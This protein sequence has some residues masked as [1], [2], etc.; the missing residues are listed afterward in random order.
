MALDFIK[1]IKGLVIRE[2]SDMTKQLQVQVSASATTGTKTTVEAAQTANRTLTLPNATDTLVGKATSDTLTNK[3][4][5]ADGAGNSITN[6]E[7]ADIKAAAAI[8][9]TKL[10]A[11]TVS[12]ALQSDGSGVISASSVT[13]AELGYVSG[14]TSA[15]QTQINGKI[16]LADSVTLTNKTIDGDDNTIQDLPITALKTNLTDASKF[17]VRD[18]S[19]V[20]TSATKDVPA[21]VV[22]GTTDTQTLTN[23]SLSDSTTFFIDETNPTSKMQFQLSGIT[24]GNTRSIA[25]PDADTTLVGTDVSQALSNKTLTSPGIDIAVLDGQASTPSNPS[26]GFYKLY[27]KDSTSKLTVLNSGGTETSVG[28]FS[29]STVGA[30]PNADGATFNTGTGAFNLELADATHPGIVS[31]ASQTMAGLKTFSSG[32]S[33]QTLFALS[34]VSDAATTGADA[35][36]PTPAQPQVR[37]THASLTSVAG[38][39]TAGSNHLR[40]VANLTGATITIRN[41]GLVATAADRILTGTGN[42]ISL[43]NNAVLLIT[44]N[45]ATSRWYVV[46]G[47][48]SSGTR[49]VVTKTADYTVTATDDVILL[50]AGSANVKI[51]LPAATGLSGKQ[52]SIKRIDGAELTHTATVGG[53]M[54]DTI[55][56]LAL[57]SLT[58]AYDSITVICN[59]STWYSL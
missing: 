19:G 18:A 56:G 17:M 8:A 49:A 44:Y 41:E 32:T 29:L 38:M 27:V 24:P 1:F 43:A 46:G 20:P 12:R 10:A 37:L 31:I 34:G 6:I 5:D 39:A 28:A 58:R 15:I 47:S 57:L 3:T 25:I 7:N 30:S 13:S 54:T 45:I 35:T 2:E 50:D 40:T 51:T 53:T 4:I 21:G 11:T 16:G 48:G 55:D 23:K 26:S 9:L 42:D 14:V 52:Y 59:G 36:I 22:L 33:T